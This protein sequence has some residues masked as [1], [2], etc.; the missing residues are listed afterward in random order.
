MAQQVLYVDPA[1]GQDN[2][3]GRSANQPLKTITAALR[4]SQGDTQIQLQAGLY[5]ANSG[6]QFPLVIPS[7][8]ELVG[9]PGGGRPTA[10]VQGSGP[11]QHPVLGSQV[12]ASVL[13]DGAKLNQVTIINTQAQGIG[14]LLAEGRPQLAGVVV[15]KCP[16][17]GAVT[18]G[19]ALPFVQ[20]CVFEDCG[21]AIAWFTQSKGQFERV[22]CQKNQ[23]ALLIQDSAAPLILSCGLER[24]VTGIAIADTANPVLRHNRIRQNQTVGLTLTGQ[25]T[26]DFGQAED[27]GHNIVR[28]NGTVDIKNGSGRSLVSCGNDVLPQRIQG[29]V[30]L[31]ASARPDPAAVPSILF[32]QPTSWAAGEPVEPGG[33]EASES[34]PPPQGSIQFSDMARHW[35]GPFVDGLAQAGTVAGFTDGTFRPERSLTRAEFA[36][37]IVANFPD[38]SEQ[39]TPQRFTDVSPN[40]WAYTAL[41]QAQRLGFLSG[42]PDGT[43]R[44]HEPIT[45]IQAIVAVTNG[46]QLTGG[47]VDDV[48]IYRDR[49]QIPSYAVDALST[50]TRHR[51]VVNYPD[52]IQLRPLETM[53]RGAVSAL[54]YQGRVAVGASTAIASP[55]I[56]RPDTTQPLFSDL[57][58]HWARDFIQGL[59]AVNLVTGLQDGRFTPDDAITRA[60]FATL[61]VKAFQPVPV[62]P[63]VQ[64]KDVPSDYWAAAAIQQAYRGEFM[65]GFPDL[66]FAPEHPLLRVQTWVALVNGLDW[67]ALPTDALVL[68]PF[69]DASTLPRYGLQ[70]TSVAITQNLI[71]NYPD[72]QA[73]RPNQVT[74]RAEVCVAIYQA[75]VALQ[76]LPAIASTYVI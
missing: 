70:Q 31:I 12:A 58:A 68:S 2:R 22:F 53:T 36:A 28:L 25:A 23:T 5:T 40:F 34:P 47:R 55:Y 19:K 42:F 74:T 45:R 39:T 56:V 16:Q 35:A 24:N 37:F 27:L 10:I 63:A 61:V 57:T 13:Q 18:L 3:E 48:G 33:A 1:Q 71:A 41:S 29:R 69:A 7:G 72:R 49:A 51:L 65:A 26:A 54:I 76:R 15:M 30:D 62:Q 11:V 38:V 9:Q 52:P 8:C 43:L 67:A 75:L 17:Y 14:L 21:T 20:D 32:D 60:Q 73:L 66:T 44:P 64:F 50:A 6:E 59:A 4:L 46:L